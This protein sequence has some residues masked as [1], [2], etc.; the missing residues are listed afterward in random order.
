MPEGVMDDSR[1]L[2]YP[3]SRSAGDVGDFSDLDIDIWARYDIA[4]RINKHAY[5]S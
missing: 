4:G 3:S 1:A 2:Q 5:T